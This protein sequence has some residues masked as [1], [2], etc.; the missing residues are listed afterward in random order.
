MGTMPMSGYRHFSALYP[1]GSRIPRRRPPR[2]H[3]AV[4]GQALSPRKRSKTRRGQQKHLAISEGDG[5]FDG[6]PIGDPYAEVVIHGFFGCR[7]GLYA[8]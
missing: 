7:T 5:L 2:A 3:I 6:V 1:L 8:L 4:P